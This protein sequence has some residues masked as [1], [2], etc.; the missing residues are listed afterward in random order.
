MH[1]LR[2][3]MLAL[4]IL[5]AGLLA[6]AP[7]LAQ[8]APDITGSWSGAIALPTGDITLV[9]D[10]TRSDDGALAATI[11]N[12]DQNP[13]TKAEIT[14]ITVTGGKLDFRVAPISA[15]YEGTWDAAAQQWKGTL[16]Q[17][18]D[19]PLNL[20]RGA[21]PPKPVIAGLDG[22]WVGSV[23]R[24]GVKLRQVLG[25]RTVEERGT[26]ALYSSPDQMAN[27]LP[28]TDLVREGQAVS[29]S[30]LHGLAKFAGT[31]SDDGAE[32]TGTWTAPNQPD[33]TMTFTKA[34]E[35]QIAARLNP[36]RPQTPKEPFPYKAEDVAFDNPAFP[37]V[38]LAGTLTLP[39]GEGPFPAA[40][41]ITGSGG[42]D[43]DE[44]LLE[45]KPFAVIADYLTRHGIAVLRF[46]DRGVGKS[47]GTYATATSADLATDAN[48][49]FAYLATRPEIRHDA[50]GMIGHSEGGMIGPI[51]MASNSKVA[52][53]VSLAGPG[54]DL[55]QLML[56][57]RRLLTTQMGLSQEEIDR[58]EPVMAALFKAIREADTPEAGRAAAMAVLTPEA[59]TAL[60]LT[61]ETDGA[62]IVNQISGPWYQ[63]F[64]KYDPAPNWS[65]MRAPLLALGGSL[66][67]QVPSAAN[68]AAIRAA[69]K[70]NPDVTI[71]EL[72][73][74]NHLFQHATTGAVGEYRDIEETFSPEALALIGDWIAKRFVKP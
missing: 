72:P 37:D 71:V 32:L 56:S 33:V 73:E 53:F 28:V 11:E 25:I 74:L 27:G 6:G 49:A 17:G 1:G 15:H 26:F 57:Q 21:P 51:A 19:L 70:D 41:M 45:H 4:G 61:R 66:D 31:L 48:A 14:E 54:T 63:Y 43:R 69:T 65:R 68:L 22:V 55:D 12:V 13:G 42:Q 60:G 39:E 64:L 16:T 38:R 35:E 5:L 36:A 67:L 52:F 59:K 50:I 2:R 3:F 62:I 58:Q 24:N 30:T 29:L 23:E 40:I 18:Q 20:S 46:D 44:T 34:S 10:V 8:D 47:T 7:A 9:L